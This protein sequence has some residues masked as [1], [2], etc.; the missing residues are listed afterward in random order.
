MLKPMRNINVSK[1]GI[2]RFVLFLVSA[3]V[4][5]AF[6]GCATMGESKPAPVTVPQI[7][8]MAKSGVPADDIIAKMKASRTA[9]RLKASQLAKL[10]NEGVPAKVIN[11][12]QKTYI[13]AVKRDTRYNDWANWTMDDDYWYGGYPY[14]WPDY[15]EE[16]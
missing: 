1:R 6:A 16:E 3:T 11:Y 9:Y 5:V 14:G 2:R 8:S 10:E 13:D 15:P 7:L 12:M 4:A